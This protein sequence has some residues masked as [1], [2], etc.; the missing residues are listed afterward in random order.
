MLYFVY[1]AE[2]TSFALL[3]FIF[4][5]LSI[6]IIMTKIVKIE[7]IIASEICL[8]NIFSVR[9]SFSPTEL[10]LSIPFLFGQDKGV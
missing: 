5:L 3:H 8:L 4:E 1:M 10:F 2:L 9:K 6:F 7:A